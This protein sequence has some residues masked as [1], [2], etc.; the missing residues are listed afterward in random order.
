MSLIS[1]TLPR[2][3]FP[4]LLFEHKNS[5]FRDDGCVE[6]GRKRRMGTWQQ[7]GSS[8]AGLTWKLLLEN[9]WHKSY[10]N[11]MQITSRSSWTHLSSYLPS[12]GPCSWGINTS[13]WELDKTGGGF[14][15]ERRSWKGTLT[16]HSNK[17]VSGPHK[18][19]KKKLLGIYWEHYTGKTSKW[20]GLGLCPDVAYNL[21]RERDAHPDICHIRLK[22]RNT[23]PFLPIPS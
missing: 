8:D 20:I 2:V 19:K 13:R 12:C 21:M 6:E 18:E 1:V 23:L 10:A 4:S 22:S 16:Y 5:E 17:T 3:P 11:C 14:A 15:W 7:K 9:R